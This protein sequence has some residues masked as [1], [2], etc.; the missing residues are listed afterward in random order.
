MLLFLF[1]S[2]TL[3]RPLVRFIVTSAITTTVA[4]IETA[5]NSKGQ[6]GSKNNDSVKCYEGDST[7]HRTII[8][9]LF[10]AIRIE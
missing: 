4:A 6:N 9:S 2:L 1:I 3:K 8:T 10:F 5:D 7:S